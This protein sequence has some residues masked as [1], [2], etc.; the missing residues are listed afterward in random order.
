MA[1]TARDIHS[2]MGLSAN[3]LNNIRS[4]LQRYENKIKAKKFMMYYKS[5]ILQKA[6]SLAKREPIYKTFNFTK[7]EHFIKEYN[8]DTNS[9]TI[10][11][12]VLSNELDAASTDYRF[13]DI[14]IDTGAAVVATRYLTILATLN[15][16]SALD[17]VL[18][19]FGILEPSIKQKYLS[20]RLN[21][22]IGNI[23]VGNDTKYYN[24]EFLVN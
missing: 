15:I 14:D 3:N 20:T 1:E 4:S 9:L 23:K 7:L 22:L 11:S 5:S 16:L 19:Q 6:E 8:L 2:G 18:Q 24:L 13:N 10:N 12:R 17:G 21:G